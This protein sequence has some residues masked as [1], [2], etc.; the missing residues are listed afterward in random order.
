MASTRA[1]IPSVN[2]LS[3]RTASACSSSFVNTSR[4]AAIT[5]LSCSTTEGSIP[6]RG[7][8]RP[9]LPRPPRGRLL[10]GCVLVPVPRELVKLCALPEPNRDGKAS[11]PKPDDAFPGFG[12]GHSMTSRCASA[13]V[14]LWGNIYLDDGWTEPAYA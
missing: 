10:R 11:N 3:S 13:G 8:P 9:A 5:E 1:F 6:P 4:I 2:L 7:L 12:S 14:T